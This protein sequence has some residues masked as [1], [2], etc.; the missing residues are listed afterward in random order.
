MGSAGK[1]SVQQRWGGRCGY[2]GSRIGSLTARLAGAL[3]F[4]FV[5]MDAGDAVAQG[6]VS[7]TTEARQSA[8]P[9]Q[10]GGAQVHTGVSSGLDTEA[11]LQNLLA[12]HQFL[13]IEAQLDQM[14]PDEAQFY[15]G[16]LANRRNDL[17]T[18]VALLGP[19]A[20]KIAAAGAPGQEKLLRKALAE[21]YL[22]LGEWAYAAQAYRMLETRVGSQLTA[23][24][25]NELELPVKLLPLA[26]ENDPM[27]VDPY[28]AFGLPV[29]RNL[30]GLLDIPVYV[31]A[32]PHSWML[33][34]T[35]PFNLIARSLAREAGLT[36]SDAAVTVHT[37]TGRPMQVHMTVIPRFTI[38]G[39]ITFH[40]MTAFVFE[41]ADYAFK[42]THY[43]V[44]GVLGYPAVSAFGSLSIKDNA[45]IEVQPLTSGSKDEANF[46][47]DPGAQ[48]F[49]DGDQMIVAMK[50]AG[51][52]A[53]G[54]G[55]ASGGA[56]GGAAR[57]QTA[58]AAE[59]SKPGDE[60][61]FVL[62]AS[63][64]QTYLTSRYYEEH[65]SDFTGQKMDMFTLP[66]S[67]KTPAQPAYTA[68]TVDL[69]FGPTVVS[70]HYIPVLTQ[71]VGDA[72]LDDVY[73]VLGLDAL[74]QLA[75]YTF[76]FKAMTLS[77]RNRE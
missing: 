18:S 76:D 67:P 41:D 9:A 33:E 47:S 24:E 74:D 39:A 6:T 61:M 58:K 13:R 31:D 29:N 34:P 2:L 43:Q 11:R 66:A 23:D 1:Q 37:L 36:V 50:N 22:R 53:V 28:D 75:S 20:D 65:A 54:G 70:V 8:K 10:Q 16:I 64:Q 51:A 44:Q 40:D 46:R 42:E 35:A 30:L 17:K 19:L 26:A 38:G 4:C 48:F 56:A 25:Q 45:T 63:G 15:R 62:D 21:D 73:G 55:A 52:A 14:P 57:A 3:V 69:A 7:Q 71:P 12:D 68:E 72:A 77:V 49:F 27:T 5:A 32:R 60:R 59:G